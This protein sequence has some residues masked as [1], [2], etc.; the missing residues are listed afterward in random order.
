M[1]KRLIL[2]GC[3]LA[4]CFNFGFAQDEAVKVE[5]EGRYWITELDGKAA[6]ADAGIGG[7]EFD[8][9]SDLGIDEDDFPDGR[10][11]INIGPAQWRFAYLQGDYSGSQNLTQAITF[12]GKTYT[13]GTN[14][15]SD[16][17]FIYLRFG[18]IWNLF[19]WNKL[20]IGAVIET[21]ALLADIELDA[22]SLG[23]SDSQ[24]II[25]GLPTLGASFELRPI[26]MVNLFAEISGLGAGSYGYFFDTEAGIKLIPFKN[27]SI[28]AGYRMIDVEL[29]YEDNSLEFDTGGPFVGGTLRF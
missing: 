2:V 13:L 9:T 17:D 10:V 21:K 11:T 25:G 24:D 27:F 7:T 1:L 6:V 29:D 18:R 22:P 26:K 16:F 23:F 8:L 12:K 28:V 5:F 4:V 19:D 14:V 15:S 20:K 3:F